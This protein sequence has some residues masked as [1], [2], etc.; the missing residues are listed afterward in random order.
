MVIYEVNLSVDNEI[1]DEYA[2]W[3]GPHIKEMLEIEGFLSAEWFEVESDDEANVHWCIQYRL[4]DRTSLETYFIEHAKRMRASGVN[5]FAE[6]FTA[7]RRIL[8]RYSSVESF[9]ECKVT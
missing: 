1:A 4:K 9:L 7:R 8:S 3:L 5:Q 2:A 6:G